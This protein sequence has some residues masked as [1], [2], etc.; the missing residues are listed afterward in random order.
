MTDKDIMRSSESLLFFLVVALVPLLVASS[1]D[2]FGKFGKFGKLYRA[3]YAICSDD[4]GELYLHLLPFLK[5]YLQ[6]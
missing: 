4:P 3:K 5:I 2:C 1:N 6:F